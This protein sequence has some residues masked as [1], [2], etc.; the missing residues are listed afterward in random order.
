MWQVLKVFQMGAARYSE[1][2]LTRRSASPKIKWGPLVQKE[3]KVR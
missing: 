2:P 3:N 1:G